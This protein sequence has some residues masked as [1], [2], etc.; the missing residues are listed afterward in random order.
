VIFLKA[1]V[2]LVAQP[3]LGDLVDKTLRKREYALLSNL[4]VSLTGLS[5]VLLLVYEWVIFALIVQ[6][7]A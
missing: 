5:F 6:G 4:V 7:I 3:L 2:A 1:I